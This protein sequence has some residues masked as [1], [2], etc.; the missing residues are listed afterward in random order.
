MRNYAGQGCVDDQEPNLFSA[1]TS[2][3]F[4]LLQQTIHY[5]KIKIWTKNFFNL[6]QLQ[7][8]A[9]EHLAVSCR[10]NYIVMG[11]IVY[12]GCEYTWPYRIADLVQHAEI[13]AVTRMRIN[14]YNQV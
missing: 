5:T 11:N 3:Q 10:T 14:L 6:W 8:C 4:C 2:P 9:N 7:Y 13:K 1:G 12:V